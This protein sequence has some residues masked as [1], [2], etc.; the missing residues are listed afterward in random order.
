MMGWIE[1]EPAVFDGGVGRFDFGAV[2]EPSVP[3]RL[4]DFLNESR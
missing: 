3:F 1:V 2:A 4:C